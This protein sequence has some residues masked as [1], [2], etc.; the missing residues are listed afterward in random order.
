MKKK[1][2]V[3]V[4]LS[5]ALACSLSGAAQD[6]GAWYAASSSASSITGDMIIGDGRITIDFMNFPL[7]QIRALEPAE[8]GAVFDADS[9]AG[10]KGNLYRLRVPA[11][12]RFLH[13]N[14]LCASE[15]TQW[16]ATYVEGKTL[17]VALFS[18]PSMPV[19]TFD[20]LS[21]SNDL[22]GTFTYTR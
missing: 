3:G 7:A 13:H 4:V 2:L 9:N 5:L 21:H 1:F 11:A 22:C 12:Q 19:F 16:M 14:T 15:D 20:A 6:R 18:G 8:V 10:A 17:H